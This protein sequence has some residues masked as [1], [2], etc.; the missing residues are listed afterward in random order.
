M[1]K[2]MW[3][4]VPN[5]NNCS[6]AKGMDFRQI[7]TMEN[8]FPHSEGLTSCPLLL[9]SESI[10]EVEIEKC[11]PLML[12]HEKENEV[13]IYNSGEQETTDSARLGD[14]SEPLSLEASTA[15][16]TPETSGQSSV[17]YSTVLLSDQP[18]L[19][20][21]QQESL[22]SSSDEGNFSANNSDI[23]GSFPGGLWDV[24]LDSTNPRHS[25]S[26]NSVEEFSETSDQDYEAS[27]STGVAKDLYYL[28]MNEEEKQEGEEDIE[29]AQ[30]GQDKN[31]IVMRVDARPLL[32]GKNSTVDSNNVSHSIPLYLPQFRTECI[33][34]P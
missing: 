23:S 26:Y 14:S 3:K 2:L 12:E 1:R 31:E 22:S 27:E 18:A 29:E 8:L 21:K 7:D 28:E 9:V 5:P 32:E 10:C 15:A 4:D 19:L 20:Q 25:S 30:D 17:T 33:N 6:W 11:P 13:L 24:C 16:A 34:P